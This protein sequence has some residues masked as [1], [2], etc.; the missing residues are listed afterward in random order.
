[1]NRIVSFPAGTHGNFLSLCINC[2]KS[3]CVDFNVESKTFDDIKYSP[4][5]SIVC[6]PD[7]L[8]VPDDI[9]I[10]ID[11]ELLYLLQ[12]LC[13]ADA[14]NYN[15]N[16]YEKNFIINGEKHS[17]LKHIIGE[18]VSMNKKIYPRHDVKKLKWFYKNKV[19][20]VLLNND[21]W[22][23][24]YPSRYKF[25]FSAFYN[26]EKFIS[27]IKVL[28]PGADDVMIKHLFGIFH[29]NIV[30]NSKNLHTFDSIIYESWQEYVG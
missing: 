19:F 18:F 25:P 11:D 14:Q 12:L 24:D 9:G 22:R 16:E 21:K 4:S 8:G 13:R 15:I 5:I 29:K 17:I 30:H 23:E 3:N 2:L 7:L 28:V 27:N 1:M 26:L 6:K 10:V 20:G